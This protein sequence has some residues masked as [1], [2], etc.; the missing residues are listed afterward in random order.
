MKTIITY[1]TFDLLHIGHLNLLKKLK[2]MGDQLIVGV[3]TDEFNLEKGKQSIYKFQDRADIVSALE[4]VDYVIP[5]SNWEQKEND[6][7]KY[8]V[9]IFAIGSDWQGK[10][11]HLKPLCEVIYLPRTKNISS[12]AIRKSINSDKIDELKSALD[13]IKAIINTIQ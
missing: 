4:Y 6:I 3:S 12:T 13:S 1:G 5:E 8:N 7:R 10:F 9:D 2:S 11:D